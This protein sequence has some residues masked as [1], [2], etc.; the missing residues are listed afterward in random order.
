MNRTFKAMMMMTT[1]AGALLAQ[2]VVPEG[3]PIK[4]RL[5]EPLSSGHNTVGQG[6]SLTVSEDVMV[7]DK[8]VIEAGA[9]AT[10]TITLAEKKGMMGHAGKLDFAPEKIQLSD[11]RMV[12]VRTTAQAFQGKGR[13]MKS[14]IIAIGIA[15]AFWPAAPLALMMKGKDVEIP[16]GLTFTSFTDSKFTLRDEGPALALSGN[17][18][19]SEEPAGTATVAFSADIDGADVEIDGKFVGQTPGA[20]KVATGNHRMVVRYGSASWER[21][22]QVSAGNNV[23]LRA[24]LGGAEIKTASVK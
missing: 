23:N 6:V 22:L 10:G 16:S 21:T 1:V 18:V 9:R 2:T 14:G 4:L 19:A 15:A 12:A 5:S 20:F 7:G 3:T 11:G 24:L 8:V 17:K 13:G